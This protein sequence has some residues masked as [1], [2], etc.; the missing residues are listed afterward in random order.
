[1]GRILGETAIGA[2]I[3]ALFKVEIK[4][5]VKWQRNRKKKSKNPILSLFRRKI[6][7]VNYEHD[8]SLNRD[9]DSLSFKLIKVV[10][11]AGI[12]IGVAIL[13]AF[14][15]WVIRWLYQVW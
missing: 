7:D 10:G 15:I 2:F 4:T 13:L 11:I 9:L 6:E 1:M 5:F 12:I 14:W 8:A 3:S